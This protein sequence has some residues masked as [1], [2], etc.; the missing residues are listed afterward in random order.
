MLELRAG[1]TDIDRLGLHALQSSLRLNHRQL[2]IDTCFV[3]RPREFERLLV[4]FHRRVQ[5][6]LQLV[7]PADLEK[8]LREAGLFDEAF[9][10]QV[11]RAELCPV[12]KLADRV[13][14]L[15]KKIRR[16]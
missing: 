13:A 9:V 2:I 1:E 3:P 16:P 6:P 4:R 8:D 5:N 10:L 12:L 14:D 11:G 7:L 15:A